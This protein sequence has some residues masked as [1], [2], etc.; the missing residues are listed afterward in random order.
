M[1]PVLYRLDLCAGD[2]QAK[3]GRA[4]QQDRVSHYQWR[5]VC[6]D[7]DADANLDASDEPLEVVVWPGSHLNAPAHRRR[8]LGPAQAHAFGAEG[9]DFTEHCANIQ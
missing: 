9:A 7:A 8:V 4:W 6:A 2:Q 1:H 5:A 3:V